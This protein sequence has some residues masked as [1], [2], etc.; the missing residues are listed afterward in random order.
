MIKKNE[1]F[2]L[3]IEYVNPMAVEVRESNKINQLEVGTWILTVGLAMKDDL[4]PH[5]TGGLRGRN[6][7]VASFEVCFP[8]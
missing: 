1:N 8:C 4:L 7:T 6:I 3:T 2:H 5:V